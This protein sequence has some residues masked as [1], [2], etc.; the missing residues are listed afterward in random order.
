MRVVTSA[1]KREEFPAGVHVGVL[2]AAVGKA[3][4][5]LAVPF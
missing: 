2:S 3:G 1:A 4:R 5:T